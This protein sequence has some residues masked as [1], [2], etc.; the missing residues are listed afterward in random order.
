M[1]ILNGWL[2]WN[3][4]PQQ[5]SLPLPRSQVGLDPWLCAAAAALLAWGLVMVASASVAQAQK[6]TN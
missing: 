3:S 2:R 4:E 5:L 1:A 6:M